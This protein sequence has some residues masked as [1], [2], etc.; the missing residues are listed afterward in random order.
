MKKIF[1]TGTDTDCGKTYVSC[2]LLDHWNKQHKK[3]LA[4]KPFASGSV[5]GVNNDA[6][7]LQK[8]ASE[9]IDYDV[10]NPHCFEP[11]IAPHI[12]AARQG[13]TLT[14]EKLRQAID[15]I[16]QFPADQLLI[17]GAGGWCVPLNDNLLYGDAIAALKIPVVFVVGMTLG[18]LN[19][20]LLTE[21]A[22]LQSG[23]TCLGWIANQR[24]PDML[25][26]AENLDTLK[27]HLNTPML[28]EV[29]FGC[30][31]IDTSL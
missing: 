12:A 23:A 31:T 8:H 15:D 4:L 9:S 20:A 5:N 7:A 16:S 21:A 10:V 24:D 29:A 27:R 22:I 17:E 30:R 14:I 25:E 11:P 1:I 2:C 28:G 3:T 18:C 13:T 19:H 26:Y 6:L